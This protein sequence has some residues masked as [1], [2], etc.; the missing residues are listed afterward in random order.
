MNVSTMVRM[1]ALSAV[2]AVAVA[3]GDSPVAPTLATPAGLE[4]GPSFAASQYQTTITI[5]P[6]VSKTYTFGQHT[7]RIPAGAVC[8][9][10]GYGPLFWDDDCTP[11]TT[12]TSMTV[13]YTDGSQPTVVFGQD[14][15]FRPAAGWVVLGLK[16][17]GPLDTQLKYGVLYNPTGTT[18]LIDE[19]LTDS[20]LRAWRSE[21]NVI[22]R[23]L[24]HF[25]GYNVSLGVFSES[26]DGSTELQ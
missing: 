11:K 21:G 25:S 5:D 18:L 12:P 3:C 22:S 2:A 7:V 13:T 6:A 24:K 8:A 10:G 14:V 9:D 17:Q 19:S 16:V 1:T 20:T 26:G 4:T 15:R 23:R